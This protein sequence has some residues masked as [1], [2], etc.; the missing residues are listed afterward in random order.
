M[1]VLTRLQFRR[2]LFDVK[3]YAKVG[4]L[5]KGSPQSSMVGLN[6]AVNVMTAMRP[7]DDLIG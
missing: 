7:A 6:N 1:P 3:Q 5:A 2:K 4:G